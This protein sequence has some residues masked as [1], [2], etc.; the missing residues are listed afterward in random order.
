MRLTPRG[1]RLTDFAVCT[2]MGVLF[3]T[4]VLICAY[5]GTR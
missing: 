1:R 2:L 4:T 3:W 5:L